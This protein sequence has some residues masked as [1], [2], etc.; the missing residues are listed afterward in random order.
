M[1]GLTDKK[2]W[3]TDKKKLDLK[4]RD[5]K[6]LKCGSVF[7]IG[8]WIEEQADPDYGK[9][10]Q[11][12]GGKGFAKNKYPQEKADGGVNVLQKTQ[13]GQGQVIYSPGIEQQRNG[14]NNTCANEQ[15]GN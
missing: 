10:C 5:F 13:H 12:N 4:G 7:S 2:Y 1:A 3:L 9:S 6:V 15:N 11:V 14:S 8:E